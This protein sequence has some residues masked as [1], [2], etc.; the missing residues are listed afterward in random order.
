VF[1]YGTIANEDSDIPTGVPMSEEDFNTIWK[2]SPNEILYRHCEDCSD[3]HKHIYMR[4]TGDS[5]KNLPFDMLDMVLMNWF[6]TPEN[7]LGTN[8]DLYDTYGD[9]LAQTNKWSYCNYDD[10]GIGFPRDC[11]KNG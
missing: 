9:A 2:T 1:G 3:S 7:T 8:F 5:E 11:G 6:D 4:R 10:P